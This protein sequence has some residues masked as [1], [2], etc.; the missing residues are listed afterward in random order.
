MVN[1][2]ATEN[3]IFLEVIAWL[4]RCE[5]LRELLLR[6]LASGAR[7]FSRKSMSEEQH[8]LSQTLQVVGYSI[9]GNQDFHRALSHQTTLESLSLK[10]D[11]EG[12]FRDD[13]D[14]LISSICQLTKLRYL[15]LVSTSE[16]FR[17]SDILKLSS[18]LTNLED[19]SFGGYDVT[20]DLW[21]G[22]ANLHQLRSLSISA[23]SSFS[24]DGILD[25]ISILE[26]SNYG[27]TLSVMSQKADL[28]PLS[29]Y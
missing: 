1:L 19:L 7:N 4:G 26:R 20:D 6:N 9:V 18:V 22:M 25:Y 11:P 28:N 15:N 5:S 12:A 23:M 21:R 14:V 13:I 17:T 8:S 27:L 29:D 24:F 16:Y 3:D 2:E 10:A